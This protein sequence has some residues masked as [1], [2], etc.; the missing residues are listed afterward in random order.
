MEAVTIGTSIQKM[1]G[2]SHETDIEWSRGRR[3]PCALSLGNAV[4]VG[5]VGLDV[6]HG[7][8]IEKV[9]TLELQRSAFDPEQAN[10]R[11]AQGIGTKW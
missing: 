8:F 3:C 2:R 7:G 5:D 10:C 4:G 11:E 6:E 9:S 1:L